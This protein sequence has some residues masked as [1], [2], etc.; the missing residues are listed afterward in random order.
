MIGNLETFSGALARNSDRLDGI[1]AGLERMTGGAAAKARLAVTISPFP[2]LPATTEKTLPAQLVSPIR[3]R[4][5]CWTASG[6]RPCRQ[7][8]LSPMADA[9]WSDALQAGADED[10]S[11]LEDAGRFAGVSRPLEGSTATSS[12]SS[13]SASSTSRRD[14][15]WRRSNSAARCSATPAGSSTRASSAHLSP[16]KGR[17]RRRPR[18]PPWT[19]LR[20]RRHRS[21]SPG[22]HARRPIYA[23]KSAPQRRSGKGHAARDARIDGCG[24]RRRGRPGRRYRFLGDPASYSGVQRVDRFETH[25]NLVFLAG[26]EAWKIKRAVRF[27][28]MDFSTLEKRHAACMRE[29][30][31]NRRFGVRLSISAAYPLRAR[32]WQ[33]CLR[34]QT[35]T[36]SNGRCTCAGST[37]R[38]C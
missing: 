28:Y 30:E 23:G 33:T 6:S 5:R 13:I 26:S 8:C 25:G 10:P 36:S 27:P 2:R 21:W 11:G 14:P 31:I 20:Q 19:R 1:V 37:S 3:P 34:P 38:R 18:L 24:R 32:R 35:E 17:T 7:R 22:H 16:P 15:R 4:W 12:C 29:V 9:Q